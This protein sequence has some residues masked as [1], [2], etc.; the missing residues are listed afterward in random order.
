M[1]RKLETIML[2]VLGAGIGALIADW[3]NIDYI[4]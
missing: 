3:F 1:D 4:Q 2:L